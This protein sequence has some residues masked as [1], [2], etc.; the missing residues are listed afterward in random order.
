MSTTTVKPF[1]LGGMAS[2]TAEV[3]ESELATT[4]IVL[5]QPLTVYAF[6]DTC[7]WPLCTQLSVRAKSEL[8]K[9]IPWPLWLKGP[10][11]ILLLSD[12]YRDPIIRSSLILPGTF[13]IDTT[14]TR[15]QVQ[16]QRLDRLNAQMRY[17]G[18]LHALLRITREEGFQALYKG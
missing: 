8:F 7:R 12:N 18:M 5:R 14:K 1:I 9:R 3:G 16:G 13:P 11:V 2:L 10:Q 17:R 4:T 6:A 15:L